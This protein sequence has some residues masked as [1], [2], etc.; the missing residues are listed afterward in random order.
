MTSGLLLRRNFTART[1]MHEYIF[2]I[3]TIIHYFIANYMCFH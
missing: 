3:G 2:I 1:R